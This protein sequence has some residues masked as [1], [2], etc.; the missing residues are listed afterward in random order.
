MNR[1][2]IFKKDS[3]NL[4]IFKAPP[5]EDVRVISEHDYKQIISILKDIDIIN[6]IRDKNILCPDKI[7]FIK[8][9]LRMHDDIVYYKI[10]KSFIEK[11]KIFLKW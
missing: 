1:P 9:L 7:N 4:L 2:M 6:D 3:K 8:E 10:N 11:L 5:S